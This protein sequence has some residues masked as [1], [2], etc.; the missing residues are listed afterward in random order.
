MVAAA[1]FFAAPS[2]FAV[3]AAKVKICHLPPGDPANFHTITASEK[4]LP[5]HLAHGDLLGSCDENLETLCDDGDACTI[6]VVDGACSLDPSPPVNCDDGL[7]CTLDEC[8]PATGCIYSPVV[9]ND[10]DECTAD[11][12]D[13]GTGEC[14]FGNVDCGPDSFCDPITGCEFP[15]AGIICGPSDQCHGVGTCSVDENS[16]AV[17][18]DPP[19]EDGTG[20]DDGDPQTS[21]DACDS[22]VCS[23]VPV[24]VDCSTPTPGR[25]CD[26]SD[27]NGTNFDGLWTQTGEGVTCVEQICPPNDACM[28][29][30]NG[31]SVCGE[32]HCLNGFGGP[33]CESDP[34]L[35]CGTVNNCGFP[36]GECAGDG[37]GPAE[38]VCFDGYTGDNCDVAPVCD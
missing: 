4:A 13:P 20:C 32:L 9:C 2:A 15:C 8:N 3:P 12:C 30:P 10:G 17:C 26:T 38:C 37:F 1:M 33:L 27:P 16:Q 35:D 14:E 11:V 7:L 29:G 31:V 6:D 25:L 22:G 5:A 34:N 19:L 28:P 23:G 21:D 24:P 18:D 36:H